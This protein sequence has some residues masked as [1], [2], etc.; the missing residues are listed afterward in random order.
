MNPLLFF[1]FT[2]RFLNVK[3][4]FLLDYYATNHIISNKQTHMWY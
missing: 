3:L 4:N 1:L 2:F